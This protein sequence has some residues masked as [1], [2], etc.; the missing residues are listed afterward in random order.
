MPRAK[1][2]QVIENRHTFGTFER[3]WVV[4]QEDFLKTRLN[5]A[6]IGVATGAVVLPV[7]VALGGCALGYGA[8][9]GMCAIAGA[10]P[11]SP[12]PSL[13]W[14][15]STTQKDGTENDLRQDEGSWLG[16]LL[17]LTGL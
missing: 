15:T 14:L 17:R 12:I 11:K 4:E 1:P 9:A 6:S 8:Y 5:I 7:A 10:I 3:R 13:D 16:A 2:T